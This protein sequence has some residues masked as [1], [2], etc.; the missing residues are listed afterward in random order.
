M[1][2][3]KT[4]L[5]SG[6]ILPLAM[7]IIFSISAVIVRL[8]VRSTAMIPVRKMVLEREQAKQLA[9]MGVTIVQAQ[10]TG[11]IKTEKEK[12]KFY[13]QMLLNLNR[14]QTFALQEEVDGIDGQIQIYMSCEDGKIPLNAL[15]DFEKKKFVPSDKIDVKKLL[16]HVGFGQ[17]GSKKQDRFLVDELERVL[18]NY[19]HPL[20][21]V[22]QL[23]D[24][25]YFKG[26]ASQWLPSPPRKKEDQS[27]GTSTSKVEPLLS[28]FFT[29]E[30]SDATVQP[31]FFSA[32][33]KEVFELN[34]APS[35]DKKYEEDV[36]KIISSLKDSLDWKTQWNT[37]LSKPYGQ[38]YEKLLPAFSK[39]FNTAVGASV[40]SVVCY[41]NV[42]AVTQ[43]VLAILSQNIEQ[44][45]RVMYNIRKLYWL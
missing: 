15:W 31:L 7:I 17:R 5:S 16:A 10:L 12:Q 24:D 33:V 35:D 37:L 20:E 41:G 26:L 18:K 19:E 25:T 4:I 32:S 27:G 8:M 43:K 21:D 30:R 13:K 39:L 6:Y 22:T 23:F 44:D 11:K 29:V 42:G 36:Q 38:Q 1:M 3:K 45:G 34:Q 40:I 9:L 14:W 28:D 2:H